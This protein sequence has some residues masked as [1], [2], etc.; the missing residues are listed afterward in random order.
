[1]GSLIGFVEGFC[2]TETSQGECRCE[3]VGRTNQWVRNRR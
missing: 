2:D 1:M 3:I